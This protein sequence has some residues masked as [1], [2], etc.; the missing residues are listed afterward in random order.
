VPIPSTDISLLCDVKADDRRDEAW[1]VF[2]ARYRGVI[3]GWCPLCDGKGEREPDV[4][5]L[6]RC[7]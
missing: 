6:G 1:T 2:Q 7:A 5:D 4:I 3:L